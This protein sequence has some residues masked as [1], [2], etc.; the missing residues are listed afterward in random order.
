MNS[1]EFQ[2]SS[3]GSCIETVP[4][5]YYF[6]KIKGV[7]FRGAS[8]CLCHG[9]RYFYVN[10]YVYPQS[11]AVLCSGTVVFEVSFSTNVPQFAARC[12][13]APLLS[14]CYPLIS[15]LY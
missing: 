2:S 3:R 13:H 5:F 6:V 4:N 12:F 11:L 10:E 9:T 1:S 15:F 8:E 14:G 7:N